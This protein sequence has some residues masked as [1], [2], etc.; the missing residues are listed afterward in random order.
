MHRMQ[1]RARLNRSV[2]ENIRD[3]GY[4]HGHEGVEPL[5]GKPEGAECGESSSSYRTALEKEQEWTTIVGHT[6]INTV[7]DI[8]GF[9]G[10]GILCPTV[11]DSQGPTPKVGLVHSLFGASSWLEDISPKQVLAM[12][13][14]ARTDCANQTPSDYAKLSARLK[15]KMDYVEALERSYQF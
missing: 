5:E 9:H 15:T 2:M 8:A 3:H 10:N 4:E 12:E 6:P 1:T 11:I 13:A 7:T 14:E